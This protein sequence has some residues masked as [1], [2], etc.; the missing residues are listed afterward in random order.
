LLNV[1]DFPLVTAFKKTIDCKY[2]I[3]QSLPRIAHFLEVS[4]TAISFIFSG[5]I[6][7]EISDLRAEKHPEGGL[8]INGLDFPGYST[9]FIAC[10][11]FGAGPV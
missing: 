4:S 1:S 5:E 7:Q 8:G 3:V 2:I 11:P 9:E 6:T 10:Q